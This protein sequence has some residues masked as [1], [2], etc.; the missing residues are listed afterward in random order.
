MTNGDRV[1]ARQAELAA[2]GGQQPREL[3]GGPGGPGGPFG[4]NSPR[5][6]CWGETNGV[7]VSR[8]PPL[9][10]R[11]RGSGRARA[12]LSA[13]RPGEASG[14]ARQRPCWFCS[15]SGFLGLQTGQRNPVFT[16]P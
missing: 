3:T 12:R 7:S 6:P 13:A 5:G 9:R 4:P 11:E 14:L 15:T 8:P 10:C 16:D 2:G 1:F